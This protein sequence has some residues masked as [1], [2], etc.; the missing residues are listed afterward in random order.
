MQTSNE[1]GSS[2]VVPIKNSRP[3]LRKSTKFPHSELELW[4]ALAEFIFY[5][6]KVTEMADGW[7]GFQAWDEYPIA[8]IK[9]IEKFVATY[10]KPDGSL[11]RF[12][13]EEGI[14]PDG[15]VLNAL[16]A[17][18]RKGKYGQKVIQPE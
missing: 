16:G 14:E 9:I 4:K 18:L 13:E 2:L 3:R 8:E 15:D 12:R 7:C 1:A 6:Q 5:V 17:Y 10:C 11:D